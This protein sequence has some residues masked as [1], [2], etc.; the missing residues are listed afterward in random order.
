MKYSFIIL[1]YNRPTLFK[2]VMDHHHFFTVDESE[3]IIINNGEE[4]GVV[5]ILQHWPDSSRKYLQLGNN[6]GV[7]SGFNYGLEIAQGDIIFLMEDDILLPN[8]FLHEADTFYQYLQDDLGMIGWNPG[9]YFV[10]RDENVRCPNIFL[11][12]PA[13]D[14][15]PYLLALTDNIF[16]SCFITRQV[17]E[18]VGYFDDTLGMMGYCKQDYAYRTHNLGFYNGYICLEEEIVRAQHLDTMPDEDQVGVME[19]SRQKFIKKWQ[20]IHQLKI[21]PK[22]RFQYF[23]K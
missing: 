8:T 14:L 1:T 7:A 12:E 20:E 18:Q 11:T 4:N 2:R 15:E 5:D 3:T 9:W 22:E 19:A 6:Q 13:E 16:G 23:K 21:P 17:F 10:I